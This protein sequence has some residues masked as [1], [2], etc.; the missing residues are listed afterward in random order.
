MIP[1]I[2]IRAK[3]SK[4]KLSGDTVWGT[5][6]YVQDDPGAPEHIKENPWVGIKHDTNVVDRSE[7]CLTTLIADGWEFGP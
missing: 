6:D 4:L 5:V 3:N 2:G 1:S 7:G